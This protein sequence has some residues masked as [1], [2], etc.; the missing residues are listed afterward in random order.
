MFQKKG[1]NIIAQVPQRLKKRFLKST[2]F[3][4]L[5]L[6]TCGMQFWQP[7]GKFG[8]K[9]PKISCSKSEIDIKIQKICFLPNCAFGQVENSLDNIAGKIPMKGRNYLAQCPKMIWKFQFC[10][11][12]IFVFFKMFLW[13]RRMEFW[14]TA[15]NFPTKGQK[16]L[17][18][19]AIMNRNYTFFIKHS[20]PQ[21]VPQDT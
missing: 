2:F 5:F 10:R 14:R 11:K 8:E 7:F 13:R 16:S 18:Q 21:T 19:C 17:S 20:F 3:F 4:K 15:G 9:R 1:R 12:K 6:S